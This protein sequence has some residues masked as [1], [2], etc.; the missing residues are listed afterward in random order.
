VALAGSSDTTMAAVVPVA[1]P[2]ETPRRSASSHSRHMKSSSH[3]RPVARGSSS[4]ASK[5][6][7]GGSG[8]K[9]RV[10]DDFIDKLLNK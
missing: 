1:A 6:A 9:S 8:K 2:A 10:D 7:S 4:P 3:A 5:G